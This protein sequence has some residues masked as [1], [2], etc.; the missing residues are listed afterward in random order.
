MLTYFFRL[1][2]AR[3]K[4]M[5]S[6]NMLERLNDEIRRRTYMVRIIPHA[7]SCL[8]LVRALTVER[9][10][11]GPETIASEFGSVGRSTTKRALRQPLT[12]LRPTKARY[13]IPSAIRSLVTEATSAS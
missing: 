13:A 2:L 10:R 3:R 4:H 7:E 12:R 11:R 9:T 5:K 6:T 8:W 1:P